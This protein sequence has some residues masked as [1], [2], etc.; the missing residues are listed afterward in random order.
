M[1]TAV[2]HVADGPADAPVL[3]LSGSL[4]SSVDMWEPQVA[5]LSRRFRV[6]RLDHRG[7]GRSPVPPGPYDLPDLAGDVLALLDRL[8]VRRAHM[9]GLSLGG[10]V[11]MWLAAHAPDRID[12]LALLG[13]SADFGD[14][15]PWAERAATVRAHGTVAI[16]DT[17]VGRW[18]TPGYAAAN[19]DTVRRMRDMVAATPD[20]GY[21][22]CCGAI[23]RTDLHA[24]LPAITAPTLVL[25]GADD[26]ATPPEHAER[27]AAA[28]PGAKLTVLPD[29][30]HLASVQQAEHVT[31]ALL[32]HLDP[33]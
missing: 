3:L 4:G 12:R 22:A 15:A 31:T 29:A 1:T 32:T 33:P 5:P 16:A 20:E 11:A 8:G 6:V 2:H 18:F 25:V 24:D 23:Q 26:P 10:A 27:I 19:P 30:A 14:P 21:A 7:H 13:T 9:A 17:V 28:I